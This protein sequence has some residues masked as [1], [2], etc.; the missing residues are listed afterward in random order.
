MISQPGLLAASAPHPQAQNWV[1]AWLTVAKKAAWTSLDDVRQAY[2]ATDQLGRCLIFDVN[3]NNYRL[4]V[5][6][7]WARVAPQIDG[8]L[9]IKHFLTHAEYDKDNWKGCCS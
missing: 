6:V 5:T 2:P 9:Y 4:I 8:A 7:L 3:G 1:K